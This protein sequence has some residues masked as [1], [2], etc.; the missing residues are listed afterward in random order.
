MRII[1]WDSK[2]PQSVS[3]PLHSRAFP[4]H[5]SY[6]FSFLLHKTLRLF[7][8]SP[9]LY[10][11]WKLSEF[12]LSN[13]KM[14]WL[15]VGLINSAF[16]SIVDS[17]CFRLLLS[18]KR[19]RHTHIWIDRPFDNRPVTPLTKIPG[20][21]SMLWDAYTYHDASKQYR[22]S[23]HLIRSFGCWF[24]WFQLVQRI[25]SFTHLRTMFCSSLQSWQ[26]RVGHF[27]SYAQ[28]LKCSGGGGKL[29]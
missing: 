20:I 6:R 26:K 27:A 2:E 23:I 13:S 4:L 10:L 24:E 7:S 8:F 12:I 15:A 3:S 29:S 22:N 14:T 5:S 11:V 9:F 1:R 16:V 21:W 18:V 25:S 19:K 28:F 17:K